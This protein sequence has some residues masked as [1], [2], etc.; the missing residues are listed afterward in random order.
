MADKKPKY[1][2]RRRT[3]DVKDIVHGI[4]GGDSKQISGFIEGLKNIVSIE[5]I[6]SQ[7]KIPISI[8]NNNSLFSVNLKALESGNLNIEKSGYSTYLFPSDL[9]RALTNLAVIFVKKDS[10]LSEFAKGEFLKIKKWGD[11]DTGYKTIDEVA[12]IKYFGEIQRMFEAVVNAYDKHK[13]ILEATKQVD[14]LSE[15]ELQKIVAAIEKDKNV[16]NDGSGGNESDNSSDQDKDSAEPASV[17]E[18]PAGA[19]VPK[20]GQLPKSPSDKPLQKSDLSKEQKQKIQYETGWLYNRAVYEMFTAHGIDKSDVDPKLLDKLRLD[21]YNFTSE[22]GDKKLLQMLGSASQRQRVLL[23]FYPKFAAENPKEILEFYKYIGEKPSYKK[24]NPEEQAKFKESHADLFGEGSAQGISAIDLFKKSLADV[25][26]LDSESLSKNTQN[27]L[28]AMILQYGV[29]QEYFVKDADGKIKAIKGAKNKHDVIKIIESMSVEK[30]RITF[31]LSET[32][33]NSEIEKFKKVLI[34]YTTY[35]AS[36]LAFHIQDTSLSRGL[37]TVDD[38]E[39]KK[40]NSKGSA[41]ETTHRE[42]MTSTRSAIAKNGAETVIGGIENKNDDKKRSSRKDKIDK[43]TKQYKT[44]I[45]LW[46]NLSAKERRIVYN[47][48]GIPYNKDNKDAE[49]GFI[50]EF[51]LFDISSLQTFKNIHGSEKFTEAEQEAALKFIEDGNKYGFAEIGEQLSREQ[52]YAKFSNESFLY[53]FEDDQQMLLADYINQGEPLG[54]YP[55]ASFFDGY[56]TRELMSMA[57]EIDDSGWQPSPN[58]QNLTNWGGL[59]KRVRNSKSYKKLA[60]RFGRK[61]INPAKKLTKSFEKSAAGK[62]FKGV[63]A[64]SNVILPGSGKILYELGKKIGFKKTM[65]IIGSLLA[66]LIAKTLYALTTIGGLIGGI[67]GGT[68]GFFVAGGPVGIIPGL[69]V[70]ANIG[71]AIL[72]TSWFNALFGGKGSGPATTEAA[73]INTSANSVAAQA[74]AANEVVQ[75]S[76][77]FFGLPISL[78]AP[79]IAMFIALIV[80]VHTVFTIQSAFLIPLPDKFQSGGM[81]LG[82]LACFELMPGGNTQTIVLD[83]GGSVTLT[84]LDWDQASVDLVTAAFASVS[85]NVK[86]I[87]LLCKNGPIA[88]YKYPKNDQG[89]FGWMPSLNEMILYEGAFGSVAQAEYLL[90]HESGHI[91]ENRNPGIL[92]QFTQAA[93]A[94]DCYTYPSKCSDSEAFAEGIAL[95]ITADRFVGNMEVGAGSWP[96]RQKYPNAYNWLGQNIFG[97]P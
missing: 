40:I 30:V 12:F 55:S 92:S 66:M 14:K 9:I 17:Q 58:N 72:P 74:A 2:F 75:A 41:A 25:T 21:I 88:L 5:D 93:E 95:Y 20:V 19:E 7:E 73:T 91:I 32:I 39:A 11:Y 82:N 60:K 27:T 1:Q 26:G 59:S 22:M 52:L 36:E 50:P 3:D 53:F 43:L 34:N 94:N 56:S 49:L 76:G 18:R 54:G 65:A 42:F 77:V 37:M 23:K 87:E 69:I 68:I 46:K 6:F 16:A 44:F 67:I 90:I 80:T 13:A 38:E 84:S 81:I 63:S 29:D 78:L 57:Q 47:K 24:L 85:S 64:V 97:G 70:G 62:V 45:P 83:A 79:G 33:S 96:F 86:F 89:Y 15:E 35:R 28:D 8:G 10:N 51:L 4:Y 71:Q 31:G 48:F 61:K